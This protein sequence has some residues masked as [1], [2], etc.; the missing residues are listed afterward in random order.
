MREEIGDILFTVVNVARFHGIDP[1]DAL[2][3]TSDK[4]I[5]RFSYVEKNTD[6][7]N[8]TLFA[9]DRLWDEAKNIERGEK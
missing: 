2:R 1:E 3:F 5:R 8:S 6:V 7:Q 4:F 9:M